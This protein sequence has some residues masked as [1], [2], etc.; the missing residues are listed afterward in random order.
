MGD[1]YAAYDVDFYVGCAVTDYD[2]TKLLLFIVILR[3]YAY[4]WN[5]MGMMEMV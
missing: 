2:F 1:V 4:L 3:A 5:W